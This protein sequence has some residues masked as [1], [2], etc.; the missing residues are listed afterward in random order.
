VATLT[1]PSPS[2]QSDRIAALVEAADIGVRDIEA[3]RFVKIDNIARLDA[4]FG[5][6][7]QN[8]ISKRG[9]SYAAE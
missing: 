7:A 4:H 9:E 8:S 6:I 3:G 5:Q 1:T 2:D